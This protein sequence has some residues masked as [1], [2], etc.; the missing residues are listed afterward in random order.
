[1]EII[2]SNF[3][4]I[5]LAVTVIFIFLFK[6]I[7]KNPDALTSKFEAEKTL[8]HTPSMILKIVSKALKN[9]GFN[10]VG[11]DEEENR[12]YAQSKVT[13]SSWA[14]YVEVKINGTENKTELVFKSICAL[15]TQVYDW[16]KN[17]RN[18]KKFEKELNKLLVA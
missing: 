14:E 4:W 6:K 9:A 16:G 17:K 2:K 3:G 13:M 8:E 7:L 15:P 5:L 10:K 12:F 1:M 18:W 11:F